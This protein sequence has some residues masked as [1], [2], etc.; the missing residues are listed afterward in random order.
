[1]VDVR[2]RA[3]RAIMAETGMTYT[4]AMHENDRRLAAEA[5][6][7]DYDSDESDWAD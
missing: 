4:Q 2:K 1:M 5:A 6:A 3:I 7:E